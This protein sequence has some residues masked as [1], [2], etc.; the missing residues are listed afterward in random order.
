MILIFLIWQLSAWLI[1]RCRKQPEQPGAANGDLLAKGQSANASE[2][3][4]CTIEPVWDSVMKSRALSG[5]PNA[6]FVVERAAHA[7]GRVAA[8][9]RRLIWRGSVTSFG[10]QAMLCIF[11]MPSVKESDGLEARPVDA[12]ETT[13][14]DRDPV[15]CERGM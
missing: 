14:V 10:D 7:Q 6:R 5:P 15:R 4:A 12:V 8:S 13:R 11:P 3:S 9:R 1:F 2:R